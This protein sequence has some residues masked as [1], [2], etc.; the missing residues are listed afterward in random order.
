LKSLDSDDLYQALDGLIDRK[1]MY[2]LLQEN[3]IKSRELWYWEK[4]EKQLFEL[5]KQLL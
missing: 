1:D 3:A 2:S 5:Y 4:E